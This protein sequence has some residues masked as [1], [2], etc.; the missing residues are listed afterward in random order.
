M[1]SRITPPPPPPQQKQKKFGAFGAIF[2]LF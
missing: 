2:P 1:E